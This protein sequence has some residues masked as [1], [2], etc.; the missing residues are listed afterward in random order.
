MV[1]FDFALD[2]DLNVYLMEVRDWP[3]HDNE[4]LKSF[5]HAVTKFV[6]KYILGTFAV[7]YVLHF[8]YSKMISFKGL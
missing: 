6:V 8:N 5:V 1:R 2:E 3:V 4:T 7:W